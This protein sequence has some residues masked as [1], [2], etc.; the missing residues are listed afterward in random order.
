MIAL[1]YLF[2]HFPIIHGTVQYTLLSYQYLQYSINS[3][4]RK[5]LST[6]QYDNP[7]HQTKYNWVL[8]SVKSAHTHSPNCLSMVPIIMINTAKKEKEQCCHV[9]PKPSLSYLFEQS[10][11]SRCC[12]K[13]KIE[14]QLV[15]VTDKKHLLSPTK[16]NNN[17]THQVQK[18]CLSF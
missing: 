10:R 15:C 5:F 13:K 17:L 4:R 9:F 6:A 3:T 14:K 12:S 2:Q 8:C 11:L 7:Y 18:L 1:T 16:H